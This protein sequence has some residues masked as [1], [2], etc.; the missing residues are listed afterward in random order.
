MGHGGVQIT[1]V[2][3]R[4][5]AVQRGSMDRAKRKLMLGVE[6]VREDAI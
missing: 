3:V 1:G 6:S 5:P 4:E 2:Q